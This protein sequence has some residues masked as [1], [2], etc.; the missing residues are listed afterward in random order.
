MDIPPR[1][2]VAPRQTFP[3]VAHAGIELMKWGLVPSYEKDPLKGLVH[4]CHGGVS[5]AKATL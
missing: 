3:V 5:G 4:K 2:N 1:H